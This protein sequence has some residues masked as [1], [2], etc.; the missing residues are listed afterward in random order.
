MQ[1]ARLPQL[2]GV[3]EVPCM[4]YRCSAAA[5][6]AAARPRAGSGR[7]W[8]RSRPPAQRAAAPL[9]RLPAEAGTSCTCLASKH[10][11][12]RALHNAKTRDTH[13]APTHTR[14]KQ[15]F[16]DAEPRQLRQALRSGYESLL[17][18]DAAFAAAN[19]AEQALWKSVYYK[20]IEE[21]R[22][23]LRKAEKVCVG[24]GCRCVGGCGFV[25]VYVI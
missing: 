24:G 19:D 13:P 7:H 1:S 18:L 23:R 14:R 22:A 9:T 15:S 17:F 6:T 5:R 3:Y 25:G 11:H 10:V 21:F 2:R 8:L 4:F 20:P 12:A 16:Y